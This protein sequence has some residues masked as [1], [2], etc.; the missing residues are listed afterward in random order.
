[1][2]S[3]RAYTVFF[4]SIFRALEAAGIPA[5][6]EPS[7]LVRSDG[8]RLVSCSLISWCSG[9]S[10]TWDVTSACTVADSYLQASSREA[11]AVA[12]L[13]PLEKK[14]NTRC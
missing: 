12:E 2:L 13:S 1:M 8:K 3:R 7:G 9:K 14:P 5:T 11:G 6:K 4:V 10:L